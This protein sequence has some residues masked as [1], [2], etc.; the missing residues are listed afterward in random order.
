MA[1]G[2][3][4]P[5]DG[6]WHGD[7]NLEGKT[8]KLCFEI[9]HS[10]GGWSLLFGKPLLEQFGAVHDYGNDTL[11]IPANGKWTTLL[12]ECENPVT[13]R[14]PTKEYNNS[15]KGDV[16]SPSRQ[17][18]MPNPVRTEQVDKQDSNKQTVNVVTTTANSK[19]KRGCGRHNCRNRQELH[20]NN[21]QPSWLQR[22][23][24]AIWTVIGA[25]DDNPVEPIGDLQ[26]EI[27]VTGD[28]SLFMQ[29]SDPHNPRH[30]EEILKQVSISTDLS[31]KQREEVR[32]LITEFADC[33]A[34]SVHEVLPIPG[35]K[36]HIHVLPD[37]I[38]PKKIPH[39]RQLTQ[40]Q[41]E[42]LSDAIDELL[43][44]DI[45]EPI[46]PENVKCVS[47]ITLAQ[48]THINPGLSLDELHHKVNEEC[49]SHGI[50]P[51]HDVEAPTTPTANP[52]K[53]PTMTYDPT[54][55]QK[56]R[57]CQN[58]GALNKVTHVFPM[59]QGDIRSK[60]R[61]LSGHRWVHGFDF[62]SGFYAVSIPAESRLYLAYYVQ[63]RGYFTLKRMPF[64]LTDAPSTFAHVTADKLGDLLAKLEIEL[65]V[66]DGGMA[67]DDFKDMMTRTRQFFQRVC[68]TSLS[69]SAKKSEFFMTEIIFAGAQIGPDGVQADTTKLTAVVDW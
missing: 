12:N 39:Q 18:P 4:I 19:G 47:P 58:Y 45:I 2:R 44:A 62:A 52:V 60:Q 50:P 46:W 7:V 28:H 49:I 53:D 5:S 10:G 36:H 24:N 32:S 15:L 20:N 34:L 41:R 9:F 26:P 25:D 56:W 68:E 3:Q 37:A 38:F 54:Q 17:V 67:G 48:K 8:V 30:V 13:P 1:D 14:N 69:L 35:A 66:D 11:M 27:D 59:P 29:V 57:I 65:L 61:Q 33:F 42:Y 6:S 55:P 64:G 40:A 23:W 43:T 31:D 21:S 51:I 16:E 63:G 22:G